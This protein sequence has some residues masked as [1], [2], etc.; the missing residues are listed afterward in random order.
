M[1]CTHPVGVGFIPTLAA[2]PTAAEYRNHF[3]N[4][5]I[6]NVLHTYTV[7]VGFIPTL[8]ATSKN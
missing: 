3:D 1:C 2:T 8:P 4:P 5:L 6:A 7:G